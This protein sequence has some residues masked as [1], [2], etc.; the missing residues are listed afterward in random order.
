MVEESLEELYEQAPCGYI[1][2]LPNGA[3]VKIN[4]TFLD[5]TGYRR[6]ALLAGKRF[7]D[8]L[9]V[10][11]AVFHETHYAPLLRMQGFV[12]EIAF[13]LVCQDG[14]RLPIL[15]NTVQK[16]DASGTAV[17]NRTAIFPARDRRKYER[18]LQLARTK[19]QEA[20][21]LRDRFLALASHELRTP[22]T[23][24]LGQ[25]ELLQR[26]FVKA[27]GLGPRDQRTVEIIA[28]QAG[29]LNRMIETLLDISRIEAGQLAITRAPVDV[30]RLV[31]R[32][33]DELQSTIG[34]RV[35]EVQCT[36]PSA[37]VQGD[38]LRLEQVF[39]NLIQNALKYS[40]PTAPVSLAVRQTEAHVDVEVHD[41]GIGIPQAALPQL[42]DR[43]YRAPN[44]QASDIGGIGIG[45]YVVKEIVEMHGGHLKVASVEGEG[46]V[47]TVSLP[48]DTP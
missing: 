32:I 7:Q 33:V 14:R 47:F 26:R 18:E 11:G 17:L 34:A 16:R 23:T 13:E 28:A 19:A 9:T 43:F 20:L 22:L 40:P 37:I 15:I 41:M 12:N 4:Q 39:Q 44:V 42:F 36:I 29:R 25:I 6:E 38:E 27:N 1:S 10:A 45:L 48:L 3:F 31:S 21:D 30:C 24:L 5:W 8:L 46:S 2:T 35:I